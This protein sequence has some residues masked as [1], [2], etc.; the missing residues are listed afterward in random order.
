MNLAK[1][2]VQSNLDDLDQ[3]Q[4]QKEKDN[5]T[6][7]PRKTIAKFFLKPKKQSRRGEKK[8]SSSREVRMRVPLLFLGCLLY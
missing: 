2:L 7:T 8:W 1:P 3:E 6:G 5:E 4:Q